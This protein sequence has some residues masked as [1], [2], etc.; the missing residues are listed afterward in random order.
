MLVCGL[1]SS[2]PRCP[3]TLKELILHTAVARP[4]FFTR[5][6]QRQTT[7]GSRVY[8][9]TASRYNGQ[10]YLLNIVNNNVCVRYFQC[11]CVSQFQLDQISRS[12]QCAC[13][14]DMADK[15]DSFLPAMESRFCCGKSLATYVSVKEKLSCY[16]ILTW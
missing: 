1:W 14:K 6:R 4:L 10:Y 5:G 11:A 13:K 8:M 3:H 7:R 15:K 16:L 9:H 12:I 2:A